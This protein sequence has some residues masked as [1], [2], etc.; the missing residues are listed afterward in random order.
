MAVNDGGPAFPQTRDSWYCANLG[1]PP[2][3][4]G[5]SL[6]TW[7]AGLAMQG[8]LADS[9]CGHTA[10]EIAYLSVYQADALIAELAKVPT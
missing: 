8:M 3:P 2:A 9:R 5:M 1:E 4:S 10:G 6:R 7:L